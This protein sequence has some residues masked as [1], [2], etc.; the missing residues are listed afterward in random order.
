MEEGTNRVIG[1][2]ELHRCRR[3]Q[4]KLA[5]GDEGEAHPATHCVCPNSPVWR[6]LESRPI[7]R[8]MLLAQARMSWEGAKRPRMVYYFRDGV[9]CEMDLR[10]W[11]QLLVKHWDDFLAYDPAEAQAG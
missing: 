11:K 9:R 5:L 6:K 2:N 3:C 4:G 8:K 10:T 7:G 1:W